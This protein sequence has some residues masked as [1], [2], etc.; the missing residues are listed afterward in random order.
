MVDAA[1]Y[2][3]VIESLPF[4]V[5][6]RLEHPAARSDHVAL[7]LDLEDGS[8]VTLLTELKSSH[9]PSSIV[10]LLRSRWKDDRD[11]MLLAAP[12]IGAPLGEA[13]EREG[14]QFVDQSGNCF[15]R[16]DNRFIA[17]I[18]GR[19]A[20]K[21]SPRGR[22]MRAAGY[23]VLF[24]L[25]ARPELIGASQRDIAAAAGTSKQPV[26]DLLRR[27]VEERILV[28]RGREHVWTRGP[29]ATLLER[30]V[31]GYESTL[32]PSL[33]VGRYRLPVREPTEIEGWLEEHVEEARFGGTAGAYRLVGHYRGP[34]TVAHLGPPSEPLRR[35][36]KALASEEGELMWMDHIGDVSRMGET[37]DTVH[38]LLIYGE[39]ATDPDPRAAE[40]ASRVRQRYLPWSL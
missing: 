21:T 37:E 27:L 5:A 17:R 23:Q 12:H 15:I 3:A 14:I 31:A 22:A 24:A 33:L 11:R 25:L 32:R 20:P 36:L 1:P 8:H 18:Q 13:L 39:L 29:D 35:R 2:V 26:A 28:R 38:P 6:A 34:L 10:E 7:Q 4:V 40:V 30:W 16:V 19:T 9:L